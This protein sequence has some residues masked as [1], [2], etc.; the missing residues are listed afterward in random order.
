[1][2]RGIRCG[3]QLGDPFQRDQQ[4]G[5][6][7]TRGIQHPKL[8]N[9]LLDPRVATGHA[10]NLHLA[11]RE[12]L[13]RGVPRHAEPF[14]DNGGQSFIQCLAHEACW[15]VEG[16]R[17]LPA[18]RGH[19]PL[20]HMPQHVRRNRVPARFVLAYREV[21]S[22]EQIIH[23]LAPGD[24]RHRAPGNALEGM[25]CEE[26]TVEKGQVPQCPR[27]ADSAPGGAR[28]CAEEERRHHPA[29]EVPAGI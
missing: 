1:M 10:A 17:L 8:P 13:G 19:D 18:F 5:P 22:L 27:P 25:G 26:T 23:R 14:G 16:A 4:E 28:Q 24:V 12:F 29:L 2:R 6:R 7:T 21:E 3:A 11:A 9:R 15:S 20:E